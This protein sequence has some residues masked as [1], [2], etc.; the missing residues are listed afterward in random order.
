MSYGIRD[1]L[2]KAPK[3]LPL[4]VYRAESCARS[5]SPI[6]R[7]CVRPA[8][9]VVQAAH[10]AG[11]VHRR[12]E[13]RRVRSRLLHPQDRPRGVREP[14][15]SA[16]RRAVRIRPAADG[17]RP[18]TAA[19][20]PR[21]Q[22]GPQPAGAAAEARR[23][24][25]AA[26]RLLLPRRH[27]N[28]AARHLRAA[29]QQHPAAHAGARRLP[30]RRRLGRRDRW[31]P[32]RGEHVVVT[33]AAPRRGPAP[34][35]RTRGRRPDR[36][37]QLQ[38]AHGRAPARR[39]GAARARLPGLTGGAAG[40]PRRDMERFAVRQRTACTPSTSEARRTRGSRRARGAGRQHCRGRV[41]HGHRL[42]QPRPGRGEGA[43]AGM[44]PVVGAIQGMQLPRGLHIHANWESRPGIPGRLIMAR[45]LAERL[46][47]G[48]R[49]RSAG[50][51]P[52][53]HP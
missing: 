45:R 10:G 25:R 4:F 7:S 18:V 29:P 48:S 24:H 20:A 53:Q 36:A 37:A 8:A 30:R 28:A 34:R 5:R 2:I 27:G 9:V 26:G 39:D 13:R 11:A 40:H 17:H 35:G 32:H 49:S 44:G 21:V 43:D 52:G 47:W 15:G 33:T 50:S 14:G 1:Q 38:P 12:R 6:P 42:R 41:P 16:V 23:Q 31:R 22:R 19:R 3:D 51:A 46:A